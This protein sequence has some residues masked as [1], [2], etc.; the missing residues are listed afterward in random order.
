MAVNII[1]KL[2]F[3]SYITVLLYIQSIR[4]CQWNKQVYLLMLMECAMPPHTQSTIPHCKQ[5]WMPRVITRQ[6]ASRY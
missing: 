6:Q 2:Q 3:L 1:D 5:S 4:L